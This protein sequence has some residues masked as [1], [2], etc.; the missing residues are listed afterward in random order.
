MGLK[1]KR[2]LRAWSSQDG[3]IKYLTQKEYEDK[4]DEDF[5]TYIDSYTINRFIQLPSERVEV[6]PEQSL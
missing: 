4:L 6:R 1:V 3:N 2:S 5:S